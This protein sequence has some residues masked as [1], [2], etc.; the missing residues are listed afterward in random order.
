MRAVLVDNLVESES[1]AV[2]VECKLIVLSPEVRLCRE[3]LLLSLSTFRDRIELV[4]AKHCRTTD[5]EGTHASPNQFFVLVEE[6]FYRRH[7]LSNFF[8]LL[9]LLVF[10]GFVCHIFNVFIF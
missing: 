4:V 3:H 1:V 5:N 7:F 2:T 9:S 8:L 6:F 10:K